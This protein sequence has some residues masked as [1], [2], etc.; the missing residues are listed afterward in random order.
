[1]WSDKRPTQTQGNV[2]VE[3]KIKYRKW[4]K[5]N[6]KEARKKYKKSRQNAKRVISL[7]KEKKQ[8]ECANDLNDSLS[9]EMKFFERQSRW[10]K[11]DRI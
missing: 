6:T 10:L 8:K 9:V 4:K 5:D 11:K 1:M 7:A 2:V 3:K